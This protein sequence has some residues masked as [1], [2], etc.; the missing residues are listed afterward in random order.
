VKDF[1]GFLGLLFER[2]LVNPSLFQ[3]SFWGVADGGKFP[4]LNY[5]LLFSDDLGDM[6]SGI[7]LIRFNCFDFAGKIKMAI[8]GRVTLCLI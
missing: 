6:C 3:S 2:F 8:Q 7:F 4:T 5:F 1:A